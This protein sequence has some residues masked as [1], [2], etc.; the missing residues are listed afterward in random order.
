MSIPMLLLLV[1]AMAAIVVY[2]GWR[3]SRSKA[4]GDLA[5][6]IEFFG[7]VGSDAGDDAAEGRPEPNRAARSIE[8][9]TA[10][11]RVCATANSTSIENLAALP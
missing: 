4:K 3:V 5:D 2:L 11:H 8:D 7:G 9:M 6:R 1:V 10:E